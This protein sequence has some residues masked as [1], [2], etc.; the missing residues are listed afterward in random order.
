MRLAVRISEISE[1]RGTLIGKS[2]LAKA[3]L[4]QYR[5]ANDKS[6]DILQAFRKI[7][8]AWTRGFRQKATQ[9]RHDRRKMRI[10]ERWLGTEFIIGYLAA[11]SIVLRYAPHEPPTRLVPINRD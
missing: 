4:I 10:L 2:F 7:S 1:M 3:A 11:A 9:G 5:N 8:L 6:Q